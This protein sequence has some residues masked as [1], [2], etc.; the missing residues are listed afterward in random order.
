MINFVPFVVGGMLLSIIVYLALSL[1]SQWLGNYDLI[2][3]KIIARHSRNKISNMFFVYLDKVCVIVLLFVLSY[4]FYRALSVG[5][6]SSV[7]NTYHHFA[8]RIGYP[9]ILGMIIG[10]S[11]KKLI[12]RPRPTYRPIKIYKDGSYSFPSLHATSSI[13]LAMGMLN[14]LMTYSPFYSSSIVGIIT[15]ILA[16]GIFHITVCYSRIYLGVHYLTDVIAGSCLG[17]FIYSIFLLT[18]KRI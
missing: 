5:Y 16:L 15:A 12:K 17:F 9:W 18:F 14:I 6:H 3:T 8:I 11:I 7:F 1:D 4:F 13:I 2:T 10:T